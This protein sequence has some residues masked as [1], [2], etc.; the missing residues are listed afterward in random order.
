MRVFR[1]LPTPR[2]GRVWIA[3]WLA[4]VA[5]V[6]AAVV[7]VLAVKTPLRLVDAAVAP[8]TVTEGET[9]TVRVTYRNLDGVAA[10][11][12]RFEFDGKSLRRCPRSR[13][14][15][16]CGPASATRRR[17]R[18]L[19]VPDRCASWRPTCGVGPCRWPRDASSSRRCRRL[20]I[21]AAPTRAPVPTAP[22]RA[23]TPA[24]RTRAPIPAARRHRSGH[25][26][27][28]RP[29]TPG[30][31]ARPDPGADPG[32]IRAPTPAA[33]TRAA[34]R[35]SGPDPR[36]RL[37]GSGS[38]GSG[39]SGTADG[40]RA[41]HAGL[42]HRADPRRPV[43]DRGELR[44]DGRGLAARPRPD[45]RR[46]DDGRR[47][48]GHR[49]ARTRTDPVDPARATPRRLRRSVPPALIALG[50]IGRPAGRRPAGARHDRSAAPRC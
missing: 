2:G 47:R 21:R 38:S 43:G 8:R 20:P 16:T 13:A 5:I 24:A 49:C 34:R 48:A 45:P 44:L 40:R 46:A 18:R 37:D 33:P 6:L 31:P 12:V 25:W 17:S 26:P 3:A 50:P 10:A 28:R 39:S 41:R 35:R 36:L 27:R 4:A 23:P 22:T 15:R 29:R 11:S 1:W 42:R 32:P 7:P 30:T 14:R 9:L 19:P